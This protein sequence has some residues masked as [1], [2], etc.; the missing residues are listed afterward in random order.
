MVPREKKRFYPIPFAHP[1]NY[2]ILGYTKKIKSLFWKTKKV[3]VLKSVD[4]TEK[5]R[6]ATN[7]KGKD[8]RAFTKMAGIMRTMIRFLSDMSQIKLNYKKVRVK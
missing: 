1:K 7:Y 5:D 2:P 4:F 8:Q 6:S 3:A